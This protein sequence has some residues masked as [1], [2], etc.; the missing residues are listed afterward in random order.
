MQ[1]TNFLRGFVNAFDDFLF[2]KYWFILNDWRFQPEKN[3][4]YF[5]HMYKFFEAVI[6]QI[7]TKEFNE[8]ISSKI[9]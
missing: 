9:E 1:G 6:W 4:C 8:K 2:R 7:L 5:S 3:A